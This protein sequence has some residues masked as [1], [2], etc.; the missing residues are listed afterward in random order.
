MPKKR[1]SPEELAEQQQLAKD[2]ELATQCARLK[3]F[4]EREQALFNE[5][6]L[7]R[8]KLNHFWII[9]KKQLEDKKAELRNKERE[10][11]VR[12]L[13]Q[14]VASVCSGVCLSAGR[15]S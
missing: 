14:P 5:F 4:Q 10:I 11:Q 9:G 8:D 7:Q 12:W 2:L 3:S 6:Q 15:S 13:S 1:I